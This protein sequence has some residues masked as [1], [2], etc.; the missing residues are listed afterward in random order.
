MKNAE[1]SNKKRKNW[2]SEKEKK[3]WNMKKRKKMKNYVI[4]IQWKKKKMFFFEK[5]FCR[6]K[7]ISYICNAKN[8]KR[9]TFLKN[10]WPVRLAV[11]TQDFHSCSRGSIPLRATKKVPV[12]NLL[13]QKIFWPVR[14]A[15]RTQDFHSCSRG[16]I[17]L[18]ATKKA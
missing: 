18:R 5:I 14:L 2:S 15:V 8:R 10:T 11:R 1:N 4:D 3:G 16:S 7:K 12:V 13:Q 6:N 17:P 9:Y